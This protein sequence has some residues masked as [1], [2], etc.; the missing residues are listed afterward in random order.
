MKTLNT[1]ILLASVLFITACSENSD[2]KASDDHVWKEQ[3]DTIDKAKEVE[4]LLQDAAEQQRK[5]ID[6]QSQ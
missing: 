6:E 2:G 4:G 5:I 3:T 1:L